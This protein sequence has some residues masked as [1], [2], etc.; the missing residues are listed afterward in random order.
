[1]PSSPFP[2]DLNLSAIHPN[3][4]DKYS[5]NLHRLLKQSRTMGAYAHVFRHDDEG[6]LWL[7][8]MLD[9]DFIGCRLIQALC[10]GNKAD[11][12]CFPSVAFVAKLTCVPDFW[13]RYQAIG[14]CALDPEHQEHFI[15]RADR[16]QISPNGKQR[17]C[18]WCGQLQ[19]HRTW[20]ETIKRTAWTN[21]NA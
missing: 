9:G 16:F 2:N 7:G 19:V 11:I 5:P 12:A 8:Y 14:R 1:M 4:G 15:S 3:Q 20:T 13:T 21:R 6:T 18:L 10:S 17:T